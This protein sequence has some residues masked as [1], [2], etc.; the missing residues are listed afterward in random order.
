MARTKQTAR[1][2]HGGPAPRALL[3]ASGSADTKVDVKSEPTYE[4][5]RQAILA[6]QHAACQAACQQNPALLEHMKKT[7]EQYQ[8]YSAWA[9][10]SASAAAEPEKVDAGWAAMVSAMKG[11]RLSYVRFKEKIFGQTFPRFD[12]IRIKNDAKE[13]ELSGEFVV[14]AI[15]AALDVK[16]Q[17]SDQT[18]RLSLAELLSVRID[19]A[20]VAN[21]GFNAARCSFIRPGMKGDVGACLLICTS[22]KITMTLFDMA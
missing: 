6:Q 19:E 13:C 12:V 3:G 21:S 22:P 20:V 17:A 4:E 7:I 5:Q 14:R 9:P 18:A 15:G 10:A 16:T 2:S 8:A 11:A 1:K